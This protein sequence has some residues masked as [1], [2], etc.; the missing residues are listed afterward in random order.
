MTIDELIKRIEASTGPDREIDAA[1]WSLWDSRPLEECCGDGAIYKRCP[2][3]PIAFDAPP[4]YT[5]SLDAAVALVERLFPGRLREIIEAAASEWWSRPV[6]KV[7][8][9]PRYLTL[10]AL[11]AMAGKEA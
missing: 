3:D 10:A 8:E 1:L 5:S 11:R 6:F 9:F 4:D 7:E 2:D